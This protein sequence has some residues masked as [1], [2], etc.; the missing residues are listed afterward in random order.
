MAER[1]EQLFTGAGWRPMHE[2]GPPFTC[3]DYRVF[4]ASQSSR[5]FPD[6]PRRLRLGA[7]G[8]RLRARCLRPE[9]LPGA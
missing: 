8:A 5:A 4:A 6:L 2:G 3:N 9:P 7:L 1:R